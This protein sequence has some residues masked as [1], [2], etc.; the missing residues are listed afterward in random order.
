MTHKSSSSTT[1]PGRWPAPALWDAVIAAVAGGADGAV[2][3]VAVA[4]TI[5]Q[6]QDDGRLV[7]LD[8]GRLLAS[9][10]PQAFAATAL[11]AAHAGLAG[12]DRRCRPGRGDGRSGGRR[13]RRATNLKLTAPIDL[14]LAEALRGRT[15][16]CSRSPAV[17]AVNLRVG[18]GL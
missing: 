17:G 10:T 3:C 11:R 5:K 8:R 9:Q 4:D 16:T 12:S 2:P 7:T 18:P 13:R 14:A 15:G 6:R 1:P